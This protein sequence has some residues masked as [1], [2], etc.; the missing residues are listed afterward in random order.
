[1]SKQLEKYIGNTIGETACNLME[2]GIKI[3]MEEEVS[4]GIFMEL[5]TNYKLYG[6]ETENRVENIKHMLVEKLP[7]DDYISITQ[8]K[9]I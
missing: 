6:E 1:M 2:I 5:M 7:I 9:E 3:G 8:Y 4:K